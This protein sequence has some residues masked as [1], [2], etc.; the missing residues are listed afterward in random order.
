[1]YIPGLSP[2]PLVA[3][4]A[5]LRTCPARGRSAGRIQLDCR[6]PGVWTG[7]VKPGLRLERRVTVTEGPAP[8]ARVPSSQGQKEG[9]LVSLEWL[10]NTFQA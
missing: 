2:S 10:F 3:L 4:S 6:V 1:M 8:K 5:P 7:R 9:T